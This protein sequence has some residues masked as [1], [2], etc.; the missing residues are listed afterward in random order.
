MY[1]ITMKEVEN[2]TVDADKMV[3]F[4]N[5]RIGKIRVLVIDNEPWFAWKDVITALG[6]YSGYSSSLRRRISDNTDFI[7]VHIKQYGW[8][9]MYFISEIGVC[10]ALFNS[11]TVRALT[12]G[13]VIL[14]EISPLVRGTDTYNKEEVSNKKSEHE[15]TEHTKSIEVL[16]KTVDELQEKINRMSDGYA[17]IELRMEKLN[18]DID[19]RIDRVA[20]DLTNFKGSLQAVFS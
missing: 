15:E 8:K 1:N 4:E 6:Y 13:S 18:G 20:G 19:A 10:K 2:K 14:S 17:D 12:V 11:N 5:E 3:T 7:H 16:Q 9:D